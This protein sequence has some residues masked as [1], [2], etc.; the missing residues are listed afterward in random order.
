MYVF[1]KVDFSNRLSQNTTNHPTK[2]NLIKV[3]SELMNLCISECL[4]RLNLLE[5]FD[6]TN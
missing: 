2:S 5:S 6:A 4:Y 3:K 1:S